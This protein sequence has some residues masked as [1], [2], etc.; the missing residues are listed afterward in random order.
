MLQ[1]AENAR[2]DIQRALSAPHPESCTTA[3]FLGLFLAECYWY[4]QE[5]EQGLAILAKPA[6]EHSYDVE[7]LQLRAE[8]NLLKFAEADTI[9]QTSKLAL[10]AEGLFRQAL[11]LSKQQGTRSYSLRIAVGWSKLLKN[12]CRYSEAHTLLNDAYKSFDEGFAT[13][14]MQEA[15]QCL[16]QIADFMPVD[17]QSPSSLQER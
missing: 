4:L 7:R 10:E 13:A 15:R 2:L 8:F 9:E 3:S 16:A 17:R 5:A 1:E 12:Q 14:D 6:R 11:A